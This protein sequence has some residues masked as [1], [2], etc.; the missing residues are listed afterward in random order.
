VLARQLEEESLQLFH[1]LGDPV[2][3]SFASLNLGWTAYVDGDYGRAAFLFK[4]ALT[5]STQDKALFAFISTA[6]GLVALARGNE[7][8][9]CEMFTEALEWL[10]SFEDGN[11]LAKCLEG[12]S[13]LSALPPETGTYL[14]GCAE[15]IYEEMDFMIPPSEHPRH[16]ALVEKVR[17][18]LDE[19]NFNTLWGKGKALT[20]QQAIVYA[21]ECLKQ[22]V[23]KED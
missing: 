23:L 11:W 2:S 7:K 21:L 20:Y 1:D 16:D 14:L 6:L 13:G 10:K 3:V 18:Q 8:H 4:E 22:Y 5:S 17:S 12:M 19:Q 9:A 15:A